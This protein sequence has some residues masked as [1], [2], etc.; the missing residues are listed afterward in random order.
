[1]MMT[2]WQFVRNL[3]VGCQGVELLR[4]LPYA[5]RRGARLHGHVGRRGIELPVR[6]GPSISECHTVIIVGR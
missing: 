4:L 6:S 2:D 1:M 3:A 5:G